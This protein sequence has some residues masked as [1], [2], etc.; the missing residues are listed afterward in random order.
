MKLAEALAER[1]SLQD[2]LSTLTARARKA[3]MV[4]EGR[5]PTESVE[6]LLKDIDRTLNNWEQ[7]VVKI[8]QTNLATILPN[9]MSLMEA[10]AKRDALVRHIGVYQTLLSSATG[11]REFHGMI[12]REMVSLVPAISLAPLQQQIDM[13]TAERLKLDLAI[14]E[15]GWTHDLIE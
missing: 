12:P 13:L 1:K 6:Q 3:L 5:S 9:G 8:N 11:E 7:L 4:I 14:Q 15:A 2:R 10:I